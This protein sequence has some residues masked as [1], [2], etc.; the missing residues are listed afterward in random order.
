MKKTSKPVVDDDLRP[1]YDFSSLKGGVRG[2]YFRRFHVGVN[3]ALL[4]PEVAS[5][6]GRTDSARFLGYLDPSSTADRRSWATSQAE[7]SR[8]FLPR[9]LLSSPGLFGDS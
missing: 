8:H 4:E 3:L 2:K 6:R 5:V 7:E 9:R 1:E